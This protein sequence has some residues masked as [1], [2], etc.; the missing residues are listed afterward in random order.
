MSNKMFKHA[1]TLLDKIELISSINHW[2]VKN[3][4]SNLF[5]LTLHIDNWIAMDVNINN[6]YDITNKSWTVEDKTEWT[7][8]ALMFACEHPRCNHP[9]HIRFNPWSFSVCRSSFPPALHPCW[10]PSVDQS[11]N[12]LLATAPWRMFADSRQTPWVQILS[13][14][15]SGPTKQKWNIAFITD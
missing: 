4:P 6:K 9:N 1:G 5:F 12:F 14:L 2:N 3:V 11:L 10:F 13:F 15:C 8:M 7:K